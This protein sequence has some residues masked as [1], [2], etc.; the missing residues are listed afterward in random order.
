MGARPHISVKDKVTVA[1]AQA[2]GGYIWC[3]LCSKPLV[4]D[5]PRIL[6]H[7]VAR[8]FTGS[9]DVKLLAYCHKACSDLK[10]Y[11]RKATCAD[12]DIHK[13]AK[14]KRISKGGRK[15]KGRAIPSRPFGKQKRTLGRRK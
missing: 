6:E 13:I 8:A 4:S 14:A 5:E 10:T 9:D 3:P 2:T 7:L 1:I 12:S 15:R 11:G